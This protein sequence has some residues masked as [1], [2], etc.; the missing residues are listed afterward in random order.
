MIADPI[1]EIW[2][3]FNLVPRSSSTRDLGT[4]LG[5]VAKICM[6]P[7]LQIFPCSSQT[8]VN[9]YYFEFSLVGKIC[10]SRET[11]KSQT[12]WIF[13]TY[14]N[15]ALQR[16]KSSWNLTL[17]YFLLKACQFLFSEEDC[18]TFP[19][20]SS[21]AEISPCKL[22]QQPYRDILVRFCDLWRDEHFESDVCSCCRR[23]FEENCAHLDWCWLDR[24]SCLVVHS[25][26]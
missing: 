17:F 25:L 1:A 12:V 11:V 9:I 18:V 22:F 4:R 7:T 2:E 10:D 15:Q 13:P 21:F 14:E 20:S 5:S 26:M 19:F 16:L 24:L 6:L 23:V 3:A 8:I